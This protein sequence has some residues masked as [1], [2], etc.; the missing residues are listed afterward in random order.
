MAWA[1]VPGAAP[2]S[3]RDPRDRAAPPPTGAARSHSSPEPGKLMTMKPRSPLSRLD[4]SPIR[5]LV[6][7]D[8]VNLSD[9]LRMALQNKG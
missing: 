5:V 2:D 8:E 6:V 9:L 3:V 4:G 7:D 1:E